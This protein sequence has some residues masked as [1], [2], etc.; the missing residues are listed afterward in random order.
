MR[1][2]SRCRSGPAA[3]GSRPPWRLRTRCAR[4]VHSVRKRRAC[5]VRGV[6][7]G[8]AQERA[9]RVHAACTRL[10][11]TRWGDAPANLAARKSCGDALRSSW[12]MWC[13]A[14]MAHLA[15]RLSQASPLV[16]C[17]CCVSRCRSVDL[18]APFGL[19]SYSFFFG[20]RGQQ[21]VRRTLGARFG[22]GARSFPW[23][24]RVL[25]AACWPR[26][27]RVE[28]WAWS[29]GRGGVGPAGRVGAVGRWWPT[30][31]GGR[32]RSTATLCHPEA[33]PEHPDALAE[34]DGEPQLAQ[35]RRA[36]GQG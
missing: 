24:E 26:V 11:C 7:T 32:P 12:S 10:A 4:G 27:G 30:C 35:Q 29:S 34:R 22:R 18:P 19:R 36:L 16:G 6:C 14:K 21:D 25:R 3:S 9:C 13:C 23:R 17:S 31:S 20:A 2:G 33:A 28:Q 1:A 15:P 5:G 8:G